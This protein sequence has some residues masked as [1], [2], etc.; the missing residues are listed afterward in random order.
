[1]RKIAQNLR[2]AVE[3]DNHVRL[4]FAPNNLTGIPSKGKVIKKIKAGKGRQTVV[5]KM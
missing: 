2:D 1:L 5:D 3:N 4:G